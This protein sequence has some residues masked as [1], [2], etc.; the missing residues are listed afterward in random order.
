LPAAF[1]PSKTPPAQ[2]FTRRLRLSRRRGNSGGTV[3]LDGSQR[4]DVA[5]NGRRR[6]SS[7]NVIKPPS[8]T[9]LLLQLPSEALQQP[10][11]V[12]QHQQH[13]LQRQNSLGSVGGRS[14]NS[15]TSGLSSELPSTRRASARQSRARRADSVEDNHA[16]REKG[17][18]SHHPSAGGAKH[19]AMQTLFQ[20]VS[21]VHRGEGRC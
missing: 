10:Y 18:A 8:A 19:R 2:S 7:S 16:T 17:V 20:S 13:P 6:A 11:A 21:G 3:D 14:T 15:M 5:L 4:T 1:S 12:H 9:D